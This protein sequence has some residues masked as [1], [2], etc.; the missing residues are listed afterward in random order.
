VADKLTPIETIYKGYRFRSRLEARWA[1][2]MDTLGV[3]WEYESEGFNLGR[4]GWYL[5][6]FFL[7]DLDI[8][9]EIK[10]ALPADEWP[11]D[12][13]IA[14]AEAL[15]DQSGK[16]VVILCGSPGPIEEG[17]Y[18]GFLWNDSNYCWCQ[19]IECGAVG[20]QF[21]GRAG[22]NKHRANC[23]QNGNDRGAGWWSIDITIAWQA[24]RAQ[25]FEYNR[26]QSK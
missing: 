13:V 22:R 21:E 12:S 18:N 14:K 17:S 26:S 8:F 9:V 7:P 4:A 1:V 11:A 23:T 25:R 5:P 20:I 10:P 16:P 3:R 15:E 19:C 6:D 24:S 2:F